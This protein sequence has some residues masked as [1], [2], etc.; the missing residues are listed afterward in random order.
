[1]PFCLDGT[2]SVPTL[3]AEGD[4][5]SE[6][7]R[8]GQN[9]EVVAVCGAGAAGMAAALAAARAGSEVCLIEAAAHVGGTVAHVL[10]HTIGGL[11]DSGGDFLNGGLA[12]E[13]AELLAKSDPNVRRR[14]IGRTWVLSAAPEAYQAV[15]ERLLAAEPR[16][17]TF[18]SARVCAV[19]KSG[20]RLTGLQIAGP[21]GSF[22]LQTRSVVDATGT[23]AIARLL[24][25]ELIQDESRR[26]AGGFIFRLCGVAPEALAW[27]KGSALARALHEAVLNEALPPL[28]SQAWVDVG[29]RND[30]AY[31]KLAVPLP[32]DWS[33]R[34]S[35]ITKE[36]VNAQAAIVAFLQ[37]LPGFAE[38]R[39]C[40]TGKL[41][42]RDG[43]RVS[44]EY[45]L[46]VDDV[47]Q[48]RRFD[49][50]ACRCSWPIEYWDP[51]RGLTL[52]YLPDGQAYD[53]PLR[54]LKVK[55]FA[56]LWVA[57]KCL[58]ADRLAQASARV[59]GCCWSMGEAAGRAAAR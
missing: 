2:R 9:G 52:E 34:D 25:N 16:L 27:P 20:G 42:V 15:A 47:R 44:G 39:L 35:E 49:D 24:D 31:V 14:R 55:G 40:R 21:A 48:C 13:L 22:H 17:T 50:V 11:F 59:A 54:A 1:M 12:Q 6:F 41:G 43:G 30:E 38:A 7:A 3:S 8:P 51:Q 46:T 36:A 23:G 45:C 28:C 53:I 29:V 56:N 26:A 58:A 57:G 18:T 32:D 10:I 37:R 19:E 4:G 33:D 5:V